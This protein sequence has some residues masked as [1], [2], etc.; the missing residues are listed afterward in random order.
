MPQ[1]LTTYDLIFI[2]KNVAGEYEIRICFIIV[3]VI[4]AVK[5]VW[6]KCISFSTGY[7]SFGNK[8]NDRMIYR[9]RMSWELLEKIL[10]FVYS[11]Q[12]ILWN[13]VIIHDYYEW[14]SRLRK[15]RWIRLFQNLKSTNF[16]PHELQRLQ[17]E[18][19]GTRMTVTVSIDFICE[20]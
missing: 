7:E 5:V 3:I 10:H 16:S 1:P 4:V 19:C 17:A 14:R 20:T 18:I 13:W 15:I 12:W 2:Y 6:E 9:R 8:Q 11:S